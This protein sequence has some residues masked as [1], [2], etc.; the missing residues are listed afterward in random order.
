MN[1]RTFLAGAG[2]M[3]LALAAAPA[4]PALYRPAPRKRILKALKFGMV[5]EPLSVLEKFKLLREIGY[6]GA[7]LDSPSDLD[8][9]EVVAAR[10]ATGL[11]IPGLV[12]SVH[13]R[14]TLS[15]PDP[16]VRDEGRAALEHALRQARLFGAT[17]VLLVPAVVSQEVSYADAYTRSQAEIRKVL[18][19]ARE[20]GVKIALENVWNQFLLSPLE[21]AR[22]IDEFESPWIGAHFDIGNIVNFGWPEHW[23][24]TLGP[25]ILKLDVKEFSRKKRD[26]EGLWEGFG[27]EIG[28][29]DCDW[30][31]VNAALADIGYVGWAAAEVSGGNASRLRDIAARM[32]RVLPT[33]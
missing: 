1:R 25:R 13:W 17:T 29:G 4:F 12:D 19:L 9:A 8:P 23:I 2:R 32:D 27:V 18:P 22:Y 11:V 16:A 28:E 6:D 30:P 31:A 26:D 7:E 33:V 20:L 21:M 14:K 24:R 10:D 5:D 15:D 3:S